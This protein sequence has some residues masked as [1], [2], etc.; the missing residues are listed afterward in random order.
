MLTSEQ[1]AYFETFGFVMLRQLFSPTEMT[2]ISVQFD[3]ILRDERGDQPFEGE[4]RQNSSGFVN[5]PELQWLIEDDRIF[6]TMEQ[7][8]GPG[9]IWLGS[10]GSLYVGDTLW[11][12]DRSELSFRNIKILFYLDELTMDTGCLRVIPGSHRDPL[13]HALTPLRNLASSHLPAHQRTGQDPAW[14]P[15]G[16]SQ[17]DVPCYPIETSAGDV[18]FYD[19]N[20]WHAT[21][22]GGVGRRM[23]N[24]AFA[25]DPRT[26]EKIEFLRRS[27]VKAIETTRAHQPNHPLFSAGRMY[28]D[29][30]LDSDRPRVRAVTRRLVEL[31]VI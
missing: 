4:R 27:H 30:F 8:L 31:G 2:A 3:Q 29:A 19:H 18:I 1:Q 20:V 16:I 10:G 22:G 11:H 24:L 13:H 28:D 25:E 21:F 15:F 26:E 17:S 6:E 23:F 7:M 9:F 14:T 12:C 5:R